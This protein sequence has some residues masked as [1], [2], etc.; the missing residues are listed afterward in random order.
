MVFLL[1]R[2]PCNISIDLNTGGINGPEQIAVLLRNKETE[3]YEARILG[4]EELQEH[5]SNV[6]D[7]EKHLGIYRKLLHEK[8]AK[9]PKKGK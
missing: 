2:G 9:I 7:A 6:K 4:E 5:K 1:S 3:N 8:P